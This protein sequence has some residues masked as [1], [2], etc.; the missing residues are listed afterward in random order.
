MIAMSGMHDIEI[1]ET[2]LRPG[3]KLYEELLVKTEE[4]E[5]TD[6]DMIFIER[7][8]AVSMDELE[9]KLRVLRDAIKFDEDDGVRE[10]MRKVVPIFRRPEEV[11]R[12]A[13]GIVEMEDDRKGI[14][15]KETEKE[16]V[17]A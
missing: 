6:N 15:Y 10:A 2:G 11:N 4:L 16:M 9:K 13:F 8:E 7:E 17:M 1:V 5:M 12:E 14:H 3:E